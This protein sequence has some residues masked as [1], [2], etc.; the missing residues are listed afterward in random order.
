MFLGLFAARELGVL[1]P[2][3]RT[4]PAGTAWFDP[5]V[6]RRLV[7]LRVLR[8]D[9]HL[10]VRSLRWMLAPSR[11]VLSRGWNADP[12]ATLSLARAYLRRARA[13]APAARASLRRPW[14]LVQD[15]RLNS[16]IKEL[17]ERL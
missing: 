17:E 6:G 14:E 15:R 1:D 16:Q 8:A 10:P 7:T 9:D 12:N 3:G 4:L 5:E 2:T 11:E 13:N